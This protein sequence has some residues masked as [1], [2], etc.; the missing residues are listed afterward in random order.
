MSIRDAV[1]QAG[2]LAIAGFAGHSIPSDLRAL[3]KEFDLGGI[4]LFARNVESPE[5]VAEI[6]REAQTLAREL[7]L[8][9]SV[10]QEG[11]RVARLRAPFTLWPAMHTLGRSGDEQLAERFARSLAAELR[12][13]G[14]TLD[15]TPVLDILTNPRNPAI[16][17]RALATTPED[18]ARLGTAIIRTLQGEGIAACGKHFPGHGDT[19]VDSHHD[20]PLVEHPPDRLEAVEWVPFKAA[21]A[22]GVA[23]IMTG[24]LLVPAL[25]AEWP[26]T[27][28]PTIVTSLLKQKLGFPG[29][30]FTDDIGMKA[31]SARY[32][33][34]EATLRSLQ[35]GCDVVL[36]C[37]E[38]AEPQFAA[39]EMV[40]HAIEDGSLP[41]K[42]VE[43][44]LARHRRMKEQFLAPPR[45]RPLEGK[46]LRALL[47]REEHQAV[48][49][50]MAGFAS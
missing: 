21:I 49:A 6:A 37:G 5:Q 8:W 33:T 9:V 46:A 32:G 29:V 36:M 44:A 30:V 31:I 17:D 4:I 12:A 18:V 50:E 2:Q 22:A 34:P 45:P 38:A 35:A 20:L 11:G 26:G 40:I 1:R 13:V 19:S 25:D 39:M 14:V 16:G 42:R 27:L 7:P 15:F 23:G 28:S 24:H 10:D 47:G 41:L 43:D 3:A 48:A